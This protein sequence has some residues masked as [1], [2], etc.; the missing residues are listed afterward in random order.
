MSLLKRFGF[1]LAGFAIGLVF[2]T[3]FLTKK[4]EG[5]G[6]NFCY[7]PNC[8][9]LKN[10][11]SKPLSYS[12]EAQRIFRTKHLDSTDI[13][14][15]LQDGEVDFAKSDTKSQDC[16]TYYIEGKVKAKEAFLKVRNC[17]ESAQIE[18]ITLH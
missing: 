12:E 17:I 2:L 15:I 18:S 6:I 16:K 13:A 7:L 11:R 4:S 3:Y 10:I 5:A 1:Y 8:R 9:A 14:A